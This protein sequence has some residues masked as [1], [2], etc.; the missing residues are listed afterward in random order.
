[1]PSTHAHKAI[2][3]RSA[4]SLNVHATAILVIVFALITVLTFLLRRTRDTQW[5]RTEGLVEEI[6]IVA[7]HVLQ[8]KWGGDLTWKAEYRVA[9]FVRNRE[10]GVWADSG[11]R[12]DSE[13]SVQV[14]LLHLHPSCQVQY[15][16]QKPQVSIVD[17][18]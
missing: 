10:Y 14:A 6:R 4:R 1:M 15:D 13:A 5:S 9:Y 16:S 8:T 2:F 3:G 7:D 12:G 11:L 17:C 18:R